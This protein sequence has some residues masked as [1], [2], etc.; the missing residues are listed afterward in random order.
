MAR[1]W[2]SCL[3]PANFK[4]QCEIEFSIAGFG[5]RDFKRVLQ[6]EEGDR[7]VFYVRRW[8]SFG[9]IATTVSRC[10]LKWQPEI[11]RGGAY[12]CRFE[13]RPELVL[14]RAKML[15]A[16]RVVDNLSFVPA[17]LRDGP[18]WTSVLRSGLREIERQDYELIER[19]MRRIAG[20]SGG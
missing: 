6:V 8:R 1:C 11:W 5:E 7:F 20:A 4:I 18:Y 13:L 17:R 16:A 12:P 14:P 19:E 10:F 9:A 2:L 3:S 15:Q